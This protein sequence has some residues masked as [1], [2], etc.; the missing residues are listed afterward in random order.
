MKKLLLALV[1]SMAIPVPAMAADQMGMPW[2]PV[3]RAEDGRRV[4]EFFMFSCNF[5]MQSDDMFTAWGRSL[6][7]SMVF[8]QV[9][10]IVS[11]ADFNAAMAFYAVQKAQPHRL[12]AFKAE[13]FR[14]ANLAG[15]SGMDS[16][17]IIESVKAAKVSREAF[18]EAVASPL[19]AAAAERA[20]KL[21]QEYGIDM[22]P[23]V[24]VAGKYLFHAGYTGGN[25]EMLVQL[26]NGLVSREIG[27]RK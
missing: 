24:V 19:V 8:E 26:G 3:S 7:S 27:G 17:A 16:E 18:L 1:M 9:P 25:Y 5:C 22:T 4:I 11:K 6:P 13:M 2:K 14:R 15:Y 21:G 20:A 12:A 10:V 23:T